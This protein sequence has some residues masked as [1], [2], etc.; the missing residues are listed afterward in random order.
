MSIL[1]PV[2]EGWLLEPA[3]EDEEAQR[4]AYWLCQGCG[5]RQPPTVEDWREARWEDV[6]GRPG[7]KLG[8]GG[9]R[10]KRK[11]PSPATAKLRQ[12]RRRRGRGV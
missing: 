11:F 9:G 8:R 7:L 5:Y 4:G 3:W 10:R 12:W 2:C 1:C 6:R